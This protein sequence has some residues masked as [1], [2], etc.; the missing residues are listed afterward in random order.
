LISSLFFDLSAALKKEGRDPK[1]IAPGRS[2]DFDH[3]TRR[4]SPSPRLPR[5]SQCLPFAAVV[6]AVIVAD[7]KL[8]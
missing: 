2:T 1:K 8:I 5:L 3:E 7:R 4:K 6:A